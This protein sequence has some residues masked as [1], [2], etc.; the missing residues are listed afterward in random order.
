VVLRWCLLAAWVLSQEVLFSLDVRVAFNGDVPWV[1]A[2]QD[3]LEGLSVDLV[4][5]AL[6]LL[7]GQCLMLVHPIMPRRGNLFAAFD[8]LKPL[9]VEEV[10]EGHD[11]EEICKRHEDEGEHY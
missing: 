7:F 2:L 5:F 1:R 3:V 8:K 9:I 10:Q 6:F 11:G 4:L